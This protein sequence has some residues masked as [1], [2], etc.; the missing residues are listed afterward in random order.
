ML[1]STKFVNEW[2]DRR[3]DVLTEGYTENQTPISHPAKAGVTKKIISSIF[4]FAFLLSR[5]QLLK[6]DSSPLGA[7][8]FTSRRSNR[9]ISMLASLLNRSQLFKKRISS[10]TSKC[11]HL[12]IC[13]PRSKLFLLTIDPLLNKFC[14]LGKQIFL[15]KL[16]ETMG[17]YPYTLICCVVV[18]HA[19]YRPFAKKWRAKY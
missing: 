2:T 3:M 17:M 19:R 1:G 11:F 18:L 6:K 14:H 16:V 7:N 13:S 8:Y 15:L 12:G 10:F 4:I 9:Y 5:G